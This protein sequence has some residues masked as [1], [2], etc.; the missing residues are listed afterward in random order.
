MWCIM[1]VLPVKKKTKNKTETTFS[2]IGKTKCAMTESK[3]ICSLEEWV[4][5]AP[6]N[7]GKDAFD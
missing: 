3:T 1:Y 5:E 4:R 6:A 7:W 2:L